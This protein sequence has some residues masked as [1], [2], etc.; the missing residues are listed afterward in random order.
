MYLILFRFSDKFKA[1]LYN[2]KFV[3]YADGF[4]ILQFTAKIHGRPGKFHFR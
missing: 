2:F 1:I 3:N 4:N